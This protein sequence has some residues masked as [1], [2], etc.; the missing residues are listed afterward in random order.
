MKTALLRAE[1][2]LKSLSRR[3]MAAEGLRVQIRMLEADAVGIGGYDAARPKVDER[4]KKGGIRTTLEERTLLEEKEKALSEW[5]Q[6]VEKALKSLLPMEEKVLRV[7]YCSKL[8]P[9]DASAQLEQTLH[10]GRSKVYEIRNE[11]L[12][13]FALRLGLL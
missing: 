6:H 8:K 13:E 11:A 12:E 10:V 5:I 4:R 7:W 2:E 3:R 1:E 9:G